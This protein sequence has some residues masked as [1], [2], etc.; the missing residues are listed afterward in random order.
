LLPAFG[1]DSLTQIAFGSRMTSYQLMALMCFLTIKGVIDEG[2][3]LEF[4]ADYLLD[5][6]DEFADAMVQKG[7]VHP[8]RR[9]EFFRDTVTHIKSLKEIAL[10]DPR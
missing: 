7:F 8:N 10:E 3:V 1:K 4:M 6:A 5:F 9:A 2:E